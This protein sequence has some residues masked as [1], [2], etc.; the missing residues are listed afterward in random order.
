MRELFYWEEGLKAASL[1]F[2]EAIPLILMKE[3][4]QNGTIFGNILERIAVE[5]LKKCLKC[6]IKY[7]LHGTDWCDD[8]VSAVFKAFYQIEILFRLPDECPDIYFRRLPCK[9]D[10]AVPAPNGL[11]ITKLSEVVNDFH[12]MIGRYI[13]GFRNLFN[14]NQLFAFMDGR[15]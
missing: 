1:A 15:I 7:M 12:Q 9:P 3:K 14:G 6:F 8:A 4:F 11:Q 2:F 13:I 10:A 5:N